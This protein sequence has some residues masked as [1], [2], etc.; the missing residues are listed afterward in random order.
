MRVIFYFFLLS[1]F[2]NLLGVF[3][4]K[5]EKNVMGVDS[6]KWE[7]IKENKSNNLKKIIW[8]SYEDTK[9]YF[10]NQSDEKP[11]IKKKNNFREEDISI[12]KMKSSNFITEVEPFLPTNNF[13][14]FGVFKTSI[15]WK[16]SFD[17]GA[18]GGTGQQNPSFILD[19]GLSD[20]S[21]LSL[22]VSGADD[23]LY[24]LIG[25]Q[26]VNY[27]WQS[28]ALSFKKKIL[29]EEILDFGLSFVS[30]LEYWRHASGSQTAKSIYN[31]QDSSF[32]KDKF[33]NIVG[34]LSFPLSRNLNEN[35]NVFV[36]PGIVFLPEKLG[37]K[38]VE[39]NAYGNNF[40]IGSGFVFDISKNV[41]TTISYTTPLGPGNNYFDSDLNYDRKPIYSFGLG[42]DVNPKIGIEGKIT[43]SYGASP[44][45]GLLTIPSDNLPLYSAN[46][47]YKPYEEDTFLTPLNI[48]DK[49]ISHG[50]ITVNNALI[51]RAGNSQIYFDYDNKGN[52][53]G[54]YGYSLSNLF[55]LEII[56]IGSFSDLNYIGDKNLNL[57]SNYLGEDNLN[58]R[59]GGKLLI[60][61]PQKEDLYW[62]SLR[63]SVGRN[64]HTNQGYSFSELINTF[65]INNRIVFNVSPRYFFSGSES[66]GGIG[67]SSYINLL[68]NLQFIPEINTSFN[69]NSDFNSTFALRYSYLPK[70]SIDLYYSNAAGIQDI[71]QLLKDK[72]YRLGIKLNFLL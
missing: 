33:E 42:W 52:L 68:D 19:Y 6:I 64:N 29:D 63:T 41:N 15:R 67:F 28:Y 21:L 71:G 40:Y 16:S 57:Y 4:D 62:L 18:S 65:R 24:N 55:Q 66:F 61:S 58:F 46:I 13:L 14:D 9:I 1:Q 3:A 36:V 59:F 27:Y 70:K 8:K 60:F 44:S 48:R 20:S 23:D 25:G 56:N 38:G 39:Q 17:G 53:F 72:E 22:Y 69:N 32:G 54:F 49:L 37:S 31:Q 50:G 11:V 51:P 26:R 30:S 7:K 45:T 5:V 47:I 2:L 43:N 10:Q 12:K 34:A 35:F